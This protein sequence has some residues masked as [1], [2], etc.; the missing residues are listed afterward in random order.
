[1]ED[2]ELADLLRLWRDRLTP[3]GAGLPAGPRRRAPG[4]RREE[5]A[6]L[7]GISVD[8]L[9]RLEQARAEHPSAQVVG[10]L[11][12]ALRLSD[13]ERNHLLLLAGHALPDEGQVPTLITAGVQRLLDRL[14]DVQVSVHD[15]SWNLV[16]WNPLWAALLGDPSA[17]SGRDRNLVWRYFTAGPQRIV[18][19]AEAVE[20]FEEGM[21]ADLR[22]T[23]G[24]WP[25]DR[26]ARSRCHGR[27]GAADRGAVAHAGAGA[28]CRRRLARLRRC[29]R[30]AALR[31][32]RLAGRYRQCPPLV[33]FPP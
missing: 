33:R 10:A 15:A 18:R 6:L 9:T 12:R 26:A 32:R 21:V 16:A 8:Y 19:M 27:D 25:D 22:T 23:M 11:A 17:L 24:R 4:L 20:A 7:A 31:W 2:N 29:H 30:R 14:V 28:R 1:M 3:A 13:D 5:L